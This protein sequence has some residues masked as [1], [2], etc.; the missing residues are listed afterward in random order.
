MPPLKDPRYMRVLHLGQASE[1]T[2]YCNYQIITGALTIGRIVM[3]TQ[4]RTVPQMLV[5][6]P[7]V[8]YDPKK[9]RIASRPVHNAFA[10]CLVEVLRA[11]INKDY[12]S[13]ASAASSS[14]GS[15]RSVLPEL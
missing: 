10:C 13:M 4:G 15:F 12:S 1:G 7:F 14:P 3:A 11:L 8:F 2:D 5:V 6:G 9:L